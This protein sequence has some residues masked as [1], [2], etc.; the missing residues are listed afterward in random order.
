MTQ[1]H[2]WKQLLHPGWGP[3]ADLVSLPFLFAF[4]VTSV[5]VLPHLSLVIKRA[6]CRHLRSNRTLFSFSLWGRTKTPRK[7]A[8][9]RRSLAKPHLQLQMHGLPSVHGLRGPI[10]D[11]ETHQTSSCPHEDKS[12]DTVAAEK[13]RIMGTSKLPKIKIFLRSQWGPN[14]PDWRWSC[15]RVHPSF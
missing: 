11:S 3:E 2:S 13:P 12:C 9:S 15:V 8:A 1:R 6:T 7:G 10:S 14:G 4:A 5:R